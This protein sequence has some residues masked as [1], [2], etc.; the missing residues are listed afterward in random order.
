MGIYIGHDQGVCNTLNWVNKTHNIDK[1][2]ISWKKRDITFLGKVNIIKTLAISQMLYSA[3][4]LRHNDDHIKLINK[5][6]Y[7]FLWAGQDQIKRATIIGDII[8]GGI[9][10][11]DV[12]SMFN[13]IKASWI[14]RII[15]SKDGEKWAAIPK[16]FLAKFGNENIILTFII[17]TFKHYTFLL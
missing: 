9:N 12:E 2:L 14:A 15:N 17:L 16:Y 6:I 13:G 7:N 8:D 1:A 5:A 3:T 10:M 4:Y 11:I